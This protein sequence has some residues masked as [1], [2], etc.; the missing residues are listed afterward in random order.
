MAWVALLTTFTNGENSPF[1]VFLIFVLVS[2]A[3]RWRFRETLV[4]GIPLGVLFLDQG[5]Y[6]L[7]GFIWL[8]AYL[9]VGLVLGYLIQAEKR[10]RA[11]TSLFERARIARELHD[12]VVQSLTGLALHFEAERNQHDSETQ[13]ELLSSV[14]ALIRNEIHHLRELIDQLTSVDLR[15]GELMPFL[16]D[17]VEQFGNDTGILARLNLECEDATL[18]PRLSREIAGIIREALANV[19]K[20]ARAQN[21]QVRFNC[22]EKTWT[23]II[24][25]DGRGFDFS[26]RLSLAELDAMHKGPRT[27]KERVRLLKGQLIIEST[28]GAGS[29][30]TVTGPM[31]L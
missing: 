9:L 20:H 6:D 5:R 2:A 15:P 28:R 16:V 25:D 22:D 18:P 30:L 31:K 27:I 14:P 23:L 8:S 24:E 17:L 11:E 26:G 12:G 21:V 4:T 13:R 10:F 1:F 3:Y 29:R 7:N 19:R